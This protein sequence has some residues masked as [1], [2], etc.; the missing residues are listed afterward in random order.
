M[1]ILLIILA[2]I[3]FYPI[4]VMLCQ[5]CCFMILDKYTLTPIQVKIIVMLSFIFLSPLMAMIMILKYKFDT[6]DGK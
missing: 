5:G 3:I 2:I 4:C 6:G 1:E